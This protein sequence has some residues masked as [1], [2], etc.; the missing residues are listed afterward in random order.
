VSFCGLYGPF[1]GVPLCFYIL[2]AVYHAYPFPDLRRSAEQHSFFPALMKPVR[3]LSFSLEIFHIF[4]F[5][6]S[7]LRTSSI[8]FFSPASLFHLSFPLFFFFCESL[9]AV[10][11]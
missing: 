6:V 3:L 2:Y 4:F 7:L 11:F 10:S 9:L 1:S 8:P 5:L